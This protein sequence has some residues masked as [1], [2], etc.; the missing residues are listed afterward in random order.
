[1]TPRQAAQGD[2]LAAAASELLIDT[3]TRE[4]H[5]V[6]PNANSV[7]ITPAQKTT[8]IKPAPKAPTLRAN[9]SKPTDKPFPDFKFMLP[10]MKSAFSKSKPNES[11][12]PMIPSSS[13]APSRTE[14]QPQ[15]STTPANTNLERTEKN[16]APHP[17]Q[18]ITIQNQIASAPPA[19]QQPLVPQRHFGPGDADSQGNWVS[20][21]KAD[22]DYIRGLS[23]DML[24]SFMAEHA[25]QNSIQNQLLNKPQ[26]QPAVN[27]NFN[28][29][30]LQLPSQNQQKEIVDTL[31]NLEASQQQVAS[32]SSQSN[33][34]REFSSILENNLANQATSNVNVPSNVST[35]DKPQPK[36]IESE[37]QPSP[38]SKRRLLRR[39]D[40]NPGPKTQEQVAIRSSNREKRQPD[41]LQVSEIE[42]ESMTPL[43]Q[44]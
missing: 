32:G 5:F 11:P 26:L 16:K 31:R 37:I 7:S 9:S 21:W 4:R 36:P 25:R 18:T 34:A 40:M 23:D 29:P 24:L 1:M 43:D 30:L 14:Q 42:E 27:S 39:P 17:S 15:P 28:S 6:N 33:A 20:R 2:K 10:D 41:R 3:E 19:N 44:A 22:A 8:L 13:R 35:V 38:Q 12:Q